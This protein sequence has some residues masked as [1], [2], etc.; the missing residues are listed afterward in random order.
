MSEEQE[1]FRVSSDFFPRKPA[2]GRPPYGYESKDG[3]FEP[4]PSVLSL[5][6]QAMDMA[7]EGASLREA[8]DWLNA[9]AALRGYT[10]SI[11][12]VGFNN[13]FKEFRK[14][15]SKKPKKTKKQIAEEKKRLKLSRKIAAERRRA[16]AAQKRAE[17]LEALK[18]STPES[19]DLPTPSIISSPSPSSP[20]PE[21][22]PEEVQER[23]IIFKPNPGP[24]EEFLA[25]S[26]FQV[27]YGGAAG[28][29]KSYA[30]IMDP[31]RYF[32]NPSFQGLLL[33]R[34][35]DELREIKWET[36]KLYPRIFPPGHPNEAQ[37]REKDSEWRFKN[38]GRL[39]LSYLDRD[40]DVKRYQGQSFTWV[41]FDELTH[42]PSSF[43]WDYLATRVRTTDPE[44]KKHL[45]MRAT[46]NPG[47]PGHGWVKRMFIDPAPPNKAFWATNIETGEVM[48]DPL[49]GEPLF[50]RRFI[51]AR[52]SD[53]PYLAEDGVYR[54]NLL[55]QGNEK[56]IAQLLEGDWSI[57]DGAAFPEFRTSIHVI[58][59]F[60]IPKSWRRFRSMDWGYQSSHALHWYAI[61]PMDNQLIVYREWITRQKTAR[62]VAEA[63]KALEHDER[64]DYGM[65][66]SS[67]W[68]RR[69][70]GPSPAE[71]MIAYGCRWR[72]SDRS[73]GSRVAGKN[74]LHQLLRVNPETGRPGIVFFN[75]CRQIISDL[76]VAPADPHGGD[77]IDERYRQQNHAYDSIR[78]GI[79]SRPRGRDIF[80][81][82]NT[83]P[84]APIADR[85]F[86][87]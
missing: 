48:T 47:G 84:Q 7:S 76:Q 6:S 56:R 12:H 10:R 5:L 53:N 19:Q 83:G 80:D 60:D 79:M 2:Q 8:T 65:L 1:G 74:M 61:D 63:V 69:G 68:H 40:E 31:V 49:T 38:G 77:D 36:M 85:I 41:G 58:E 27:L 78:Y 66:D 37:W 72:P 14:P 59:P 34:T 45:A 18:N 16:T 39:W 87:Y 64:V 24:Q 73:Q 86:G 50:R 81:F 46:T 29:G 70:E 32:H 71:E 35:N 25:A 11:S 22:L 55:S 33:R 54:R 23:E 30:L 13:I 20:E 67:V 51:P 26:E 21:A 82:S 17:R 3:F 75:T 42:Y 43:P 52:L 4:I 15:E 9:E 57:A 44:L 62:E 28:G